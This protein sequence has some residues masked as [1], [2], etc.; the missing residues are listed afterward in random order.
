MAVRRLSRLLVV[1]GSILFSSAGVGADKAD[2]TKAGDHPPAEI[3]GVG[4][5]LDLREKQIFVAHVLPNTAAARNGIVHVGDRLIAVGQG[6]QPPVPVEGKSLN[7]VVAMVRGIKGTTV[8]LLIVPAKAAKDDAIVV[9]LVR[10][11]V[12]ELNRFG[13]GRWI[14]RGSKIADLEGI[15]LTNGGKYSLKSDLGKIVVLEF[16]FKGCAPCLKALDELGKLRQEHPEWKDRL[17]LVAV[18]VDDEKADAVRCVKEHGEHWANINVV[19]VGSE[20]LKTFHI[21]GLPATYVLDG[22]GHVLF[23]AHARD[24][25]AEIKKALAL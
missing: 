5:A 11:P 1:A 8:I 16:W 9:P 21:Q 13:D 22:Q 10:S 2:A 20:P 19:W 23:A 25:S 14:P 6:T 7:E 24:L 12:K 18:G 4:L 17:R 3:S 15:S